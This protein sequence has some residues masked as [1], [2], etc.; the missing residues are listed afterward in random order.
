M[1]THRQRAVLHKRISRALCWKAV[2][3]GYRTDAEAQATLVLDE[4]EF[5]GFSAAAG[6]RAVLK[7]VER[8][9][10]EAVG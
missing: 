3:S 5:T 9:E 6:R 8:A 4:L 1:F 7:V 2:P 10:E